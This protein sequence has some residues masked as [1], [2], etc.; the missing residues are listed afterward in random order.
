M[1]AAGCTIPREDFEALYM[2]P[3]R[4]SYD[5]SKYDFVSA[6]QKLV[7]VPA[8]ELGKL[9]LV[10]EPSQTLQPI[11]PLQQAFTLVGQADTFVGVQKAPG[12]N[13]LYA[14]YLAL[15]RQFLLGVVAPMFGSSPEALDLV[16][17]SKPIL[18]V[19]LPGKR[20]DIQLHTDSDYGHVP[21]ELNFWVPLS[22]VRG[23]CSL[24]AESKPGLGD[25][26]AFDGGPGHL[27]RWWGNQCRHYT[28]PNDTEHTRVSMD[29][30]VIPGCMW[31]ESEVEQMAATRKRRDGRK[32]ALG[33]YY[34]RLNV[35][36]DWRR[37]LSSRQWKGRRRARSKRKC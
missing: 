12:S 14:Q 15:Y 13:E 32:L 1:D 3:R 10:D 36:E 35:D 6:F 29:F 11:P 21:G 17:Q 30:R 2:Q 22:H 16:C 20:T 9:H 34:A 23:N 28:V 4:L 27:F 8:I 26:S 33:A 7:G 24:Y 31:D 37:A 25:F 5:T 19:V 18:R